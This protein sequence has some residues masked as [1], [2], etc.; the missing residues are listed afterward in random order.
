MRM[1]VSPALS[2]ARHAWLATML[3]CGL[4]QAGVARATPA[5]PLPPKAGQ[6]TLT[7]AT[8]N[9]GPDREHWLT[10]RD[11]VLSALRDL[12]PD[13][14]ALQEVLQSPEVPNQAC[15]L[16]AKLDYGCS[17]I[18]ADPPSRARREGNAL[19]T[20]HLVVE[21]AVTLLHP[22]EMASTAGMVQLDV[23]GTAVN[24]YVTQ[25]HADGGESAADAAAIR[26]AQI[27]NLLR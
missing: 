8:L 16:A 17:F 25:L 27:D 6:T 3:L 9:L 4:V 14:I 12:H 21:D 18:T 13:V 7:I 5:L 10:R 24:V 15:W 26:A 11:D 1:L 2:N 19:L 20:R 22:F 23:G